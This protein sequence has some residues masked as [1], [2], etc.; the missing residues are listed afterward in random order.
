MPKEVY[1]HSNPEENQSTSEL[2]TILKRQIHLLETQLNTTQRNS[3]KDIWDRLASISVFL[4]TVVLG[5]VALVLTTIIDSKRID[6][7]QESML[8]NNRIKELEVVTKMLPFLATNADEEL[9]KQAILAIQVLARPE[10][11]AKLAILDPSPGK[12]SAIVEGI[13]KANSLQEK[14][15]FINALKDIQASRPAIVVEEG[16]IRHDIPLMWREDIV[17]H[18]D[19]IRRI[20]QSTGKI[21]VKNHPFNSV[22]TTFVI[23]NSLI[24]L[25]DHI[26]KTFLILDNSGNWVY[27]QGLNDKVMAASVTFADIKSNTNEEYSIGQVK[28]I[29]KT[30]SRDLFILQVPNLNME[31]HPPL[32]LSDYMNL[33]LSDEESSCFI[34]GFPSKDRK[35]PEKI[36]EEIFKNT[37]NVKRFHP[38]NYKYVNGTVGSRIEHDCWTM[39]GSG[40]SPVVDFVSG[41]VIG[42]HTSGD[43]NEDGYNKTGWAI[44]IRSVTNF[45]SKEP[46]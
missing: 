5:A 29:I 26:A 34:V 42:I 13:N 12:T 28:A 18:E 10:V 22:G 46:S 4:S 3:E 19:K 7:D 32:P 11:A 39:K 35:I 1:T 2:Y 43:Y 6:N 36:L 37:F 8:E 31:K 25:P 14:E 44:P 9:K 17:K 27:R 15:I 21:V 24:I 38:G 23:D 41:K 16:T 45:L 30:D 40:G 33:Y 20:T